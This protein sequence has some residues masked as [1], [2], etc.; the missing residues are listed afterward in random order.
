MGAG[1]NE[2]YRPTASDSRRPRA[3]T[4][5]PRSACRT[6]AGRPGSTVSIAVGD[7]SW[8]AVSTGE[9][10]GQAEIAWQNNNGAV[11]IW[12]MNGTT[13]VAEAALS[14]PGAGWQLVSVDHFTPERTGRSSVPEHEWRDD[15]AVAATL[16]LPNPG[17]AWQ[18]VNGHPFA[19]MTAAPR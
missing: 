8:H 1:Q 7:P 12:L 5:R 10:N 15:D 2:H 4:S 14:N 13:P 19:R 6:S 3:R 9:F 16:N 11:D 17:A 18:S